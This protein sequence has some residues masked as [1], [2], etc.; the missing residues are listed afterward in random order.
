[1]AS[2]VSYGDSDSD[3]DGDSPLFPSQQPPAHFQCM[4]QSSGAEAEAAVAKRPRVDEKLLPDGECSSKPGA[5]AQ[6]VPE[7]ALDGM[8]P[9]N[10]QCT[11][12][13][14]GPQVDATVQSNIAALLAAHGESFVKLLRSKKEFNNPYTLEKVS[15]Y[16]GIDSFGSNFAVKPGSTFTSDDYYDALAV[17]QR[18]ASDGQSFPSSGF[19]ASVAQPLEFVP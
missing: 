3:S 12:A 10:V 18:A 11:A 7:V 16:T 5:S 1:M 19:S 2:L 14:M 13:L 8:A 9:S 6:P 17:R 4:E 15:E